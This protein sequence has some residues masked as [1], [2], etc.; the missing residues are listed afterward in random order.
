MLLSKAKARKVRFLIILFSTL[1]FLVII[2]FIGIK[3]IK[4]HSSLIITKSQFSLASPTQNHLRS[5]ITEELPVFP[6]EQKVGLLFMV[7]FEG[8]ELDQETKDF[9]SQNYFRNFL[10]LDRNIG[11]TDEIK[12]LIQSLCRLGESEAIDRIP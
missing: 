6:L 9:L 12:K 5:V 8:K 4:L 3:K 1:C 10:L 7:G 11:T 2:L